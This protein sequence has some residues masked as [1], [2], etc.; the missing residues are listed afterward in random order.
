M[1]VGKRR[2]QYLADCCVNRTSA[3]LADEGNVGSKALLNILGLDVQSPS[4][5]EEAKAITCALG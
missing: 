5:Q 3:Y 1:F 4:N 2:A